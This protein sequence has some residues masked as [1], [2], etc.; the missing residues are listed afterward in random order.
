MFNSTL[1][2]AAE[3]RQQLHATAGRAIALE[4]HLQ[5]HGIA[6]P[7]ASISPGH[8][9]ARALSEGE[10]GLLNSV[11]DRCLPDNCLAV[12]LTIESPAIAAV[13]IFPECCMQACSTCLTAGLWCMQH[14]ADATVLLI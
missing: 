7:P 8:A 3:L 6:L 13:F 1:L 12:C 10:A 5:Q 2:A 4:Q 14:T 9:L 11:A